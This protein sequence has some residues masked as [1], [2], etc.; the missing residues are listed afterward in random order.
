MRKL[1]KLREVLTIIKAVLHDAE[2]S[3]EAEE[4][5]RH[6]LEK[7]KRSQGEGAQLLCLSSPFL[8]PLNMAL[9]VKKINKFLDEL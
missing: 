1:E 8:F 6:W 9:K 4:S 2:Q 5:V 7:P 3:P